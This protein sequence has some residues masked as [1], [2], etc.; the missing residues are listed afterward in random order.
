MAIKYISQT[1]DKKW[2]VSASKSGKAI[3]I[4]DTQKEAIAYSATLKSTENILIK[5]KSGKWSRPS[6]WDQRTIKEAEDKLVETK[7]SSKNTARAKN[8]AAAA[9][10]GVKNDRK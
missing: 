3:A 9:V 6:I 2:K 5:R 10:A 7:A 1:K 4:K 8:I